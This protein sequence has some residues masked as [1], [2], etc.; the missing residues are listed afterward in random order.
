M[1]AG[2]QSKGGMIMARGYIDVSLKDIADAFV[3]KSRQEDEEKKTIEFVNGLLEARLIPAAKE[4]RYKV[5]ERKL[6][7]QVIKVLQDRYKICVVDRD[8]E[9]VL[10]WGH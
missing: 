8:E 10:S 4:G 7:P 6:S 1:V 5:I 2:K 3:D 9:T